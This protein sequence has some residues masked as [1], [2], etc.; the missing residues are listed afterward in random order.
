MTHVAMLSLH[1]SPLDQPGIGD[2]GGLNVYVRELAS[3]LARSGVT[4]DVFTRATS[5]NSPD[6]I[7]VE[8][9]FRVFNIKAGPLR[10]LSRFEFIEFLEEITNMVIK[11]I[12]DNDNDYDEPISAIHANYWLSALVGHSIKH[13]LE[14]PLI[15]TFH[16]L[17]K[18]KIAQKQGDLDLVMSQK[19]IEAESIITACSD[20][21]IASC[22]AEVNDLLTFYGLEMARSAIIAPGVEKAFFQKGKKTFAKVALEMYLRVNYPHLLNCPIADNP[23][24]LFVGRM[25]P[26]KGIDVAVGMLAMLEE[27]GIENAKL[28]AVGGPSGIGSQEWYLELKSLVK[29]AGM[30]NDIIFLPPQQHEVLATFY[31]AADCVIVPSKSESFGLVALEAMACAIPV[32]AANVGGLT[33]LITSGKDGFLVDGHDSS[34]YA[35][36]VSEILANNSLAR[37]ISINAID[38]ASK[39]TW[40]NAARRLNYVY[41]GVAQKKIIQA[42]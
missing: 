6:V 17:E 2:G 30:G 19:R 39:Y 1:T 25:Q 33:T 29:D 38:K 42:C 35:S 5:G 3:A 13:Q 21:V 32:V 18:V 4:C 31:R 27:Y 14:I 34:A 9:G 10:P 37:Y 40:Q 8:P 12:I 26:L 7:T 28:L 41:K 15:T 11:C 20:A 23:L 16:T 36:A 24:V 22:E